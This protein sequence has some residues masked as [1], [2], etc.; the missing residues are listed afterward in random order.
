MNFIGFKRLKL[1]KSC[2]MWWSTD[3]PRNSSRL[4]KWKAFCTVA[5]F[6]SGV[7]PAYSGLQRRA[8]GWE[9]V[10][11][12]PGSSRGCQRQGKFPSPASQDEVLSSGQ[13]TGSSQQA[14]ALRTGRCAGNAS[15]WRDAAGAK[16]RWQGPGALAG[17]ALP[18]HPLF[19]DW[20]GTGTGE[21]GNVDSGLSWEEVT[22]YEDLKTV[23]AC[24][25]RCL[26][27]RREEPL[28]MDREVL[29]DAAVLEVETMCHYIHN[30]L[31]VCQK[32]QMN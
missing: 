13:E 28:T 8:I 1:F 5:F 18:R 15:P 16:S 10:A 12:E 11:Q 30:S 4:G 19:A 22:A 6:S 29:T 27:R 14:Q 21:K 32:L 26:R 9:S 20:A 17:A 23:S 31:L 25:P 3:Y 2:T 24:Q 7:L